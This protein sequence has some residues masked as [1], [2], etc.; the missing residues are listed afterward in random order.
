VLDH[1]VP[2]EREILIAMQRGLD[3]PHRRRLRDRAGMAMLD[4]LFRSDR[5]VRAPQSVQQMLP[6]SDATLASI[7]EHQAHGHRDLSHFLEPLTVPQRDLGIFLRSSRGLDVRAAS[8]EVFWVH[9]HHHGFQL[10]RLT[11]AS[12]R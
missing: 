6:T 10:A 4:W 1:A 2:V 3:T 12:K 9:T 11:A 5:R 8:P 7:H